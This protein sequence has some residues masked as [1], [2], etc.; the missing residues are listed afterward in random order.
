MLKFLGCPICK[1]AVKTEYNNGNINNAYCEKCKSTFEINELIII[2]K[3]KKELKVK[4][5]KSL[6][7]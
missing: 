3:T 7:K 6:L 5:K 2:H 1:N 4:S